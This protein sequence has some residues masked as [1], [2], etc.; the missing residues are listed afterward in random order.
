MAAAQHHHRSAASGSMRLCWKTSVTL[1]WKVG[2]REGPA[3][4][5][6]EGRHLE[7]EIVL[8][9]GCAGTGAGRARGAGRSTRPT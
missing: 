8:C 4:S 3:M 9:S 5:D 1:R 6:F 7:G 2:E